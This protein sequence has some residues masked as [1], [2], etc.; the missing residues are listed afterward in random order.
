MEE[1]LDL[2]SDRILNELMNG[3][4]G[5]NVI[6]LFFVGSFIIRRNLDISILRGIRNALKILI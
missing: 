3:E 4:N 6:M 2:S 1:A 5:E